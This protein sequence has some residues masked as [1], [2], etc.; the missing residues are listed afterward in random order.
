MYIY[1]YMYTYIYIYTHTYIYI[2]SDLR[3]PKSETMP[4]SYGNELS[5]LLRDLWRL[6]N[7]KP[8]NRYTLAPPPQKKKK[9]KNTQSLKSEGL[10]P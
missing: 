8:I 5:R 9:K 10:K 1:I 7:P 3:A 4:L 6:L 2:Y